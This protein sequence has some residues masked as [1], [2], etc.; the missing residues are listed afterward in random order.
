MG[1]GAGAGAGVEDDGIEMEP[2][3]QGQDVAA[4]PTALLVAVCLA[5]DRPGQAPGF[6]RMLVP[7]A[8]NIEEVMQNLHATATVLAENDRRG[9]GC[10][11]FNC[12]CDVDIKRV[13]ICGVSFGS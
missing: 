10:G 12:F 8:A 11:F 6:S 1:A 7:T 9:C 5:R 2:P 3:Q 4:G 13:T